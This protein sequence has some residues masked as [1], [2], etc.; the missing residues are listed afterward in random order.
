MTWFNEPIRI[1]RNNNGGGILLFVREGIS[2]KFCHFNKVLSIEIFLCRKIFVKQS[3]FY[4][5]PRIT[6]Q[7]QTK[8]HLSTPLRSQE[9]LKSSPFKNVF[10]FFSIL[11]KPLG[12][13]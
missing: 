11:L 1:D 10:F 9:T 13:A 7:K 3:G 12:N 5:N 2:T 4:S 6:E 8:K